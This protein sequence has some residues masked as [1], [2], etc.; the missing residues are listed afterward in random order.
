LKPEHLYQPGRLLRRLL[1]KGSRISPSAL[2]AFGFDLDVMPDELIS[3][4]IRRKGIYDL[5]TA[6]VIYRLLDPGTYAL[7]VGA[8]VGLMSMIM[9]LRV[10]SAGS[11]AG[12]VRSFEPHPAVYAKLRANAERMNQQLGKKVIQTRNL[13]LSD[14]ARQAPL[15]LPA[16]W[17][18]NTGV[19]R[20]DSALNSVSKSAQGPVMVE[21]QTLDDACALQTPQ[22]MKIDVEG[23]ELAVLH[24][25]P[26]TLANLRDIVFEDFESY[27]TP[28]MSLLEQNGFQ[29]FALYRTLHR[30]VLV[31]PHRPGMPKDADPNYLATRDPERARQ[32]F[33]PA[34]WNVLRSLL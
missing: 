5:V 24:G 10:G 25:A 3:N 21:C 31:D 22:L 18:A 16:D 15:F 12:S 1:H 29:V 17:A 30:P 23:H 13:A 34:G 26:R 28:V 4:S 19:G 2:T 20:L 6:E 9:A 8:H 27:P 14:S 7:D 11:T 32:R 33:A